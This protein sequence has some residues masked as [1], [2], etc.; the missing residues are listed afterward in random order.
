MIT[1]SVQL[2]VPVLVK[3][4]FNLEPGEPR[5]AGDSERESR[6]NLKQGDHGIMG[7]LDH[8]RS[9]YRVGHGDVEERAYA[10]HPASVN[11]RGSEDTRLVIRDTVRQFPNPR[12]SWPVE[13]AKAVVALSGH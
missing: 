13:V 5:T 8:L 2:T 12:Q 10:S 9:W 11:M 6:A 7:P 3:L 4:R 1:E